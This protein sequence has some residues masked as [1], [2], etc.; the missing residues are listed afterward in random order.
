MP[1]EMLSISKLCE[2]VGISESFYY[3]LKRSGAGPAET[4]VGRRKLISQSAAE[5][6]LKNREEQPTTTGCR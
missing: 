1:S 5:A 2:R 3:K 4:S 6:W